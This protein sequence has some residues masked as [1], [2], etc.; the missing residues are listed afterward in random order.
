MDKQLFE[1][2]SD[3][4]LELL[5]RNEIGNIRILSIEYD[6]RC[7]I[8]EYAKIF[9]NYKGVAIDEPIIEIID[10]N[11]FEF[12]TAG[13]LSFEFIGNG[14]EMGF[15]IFT[16][17]VLRAQLCIDRQGFLIRGALT[18][19]YVSDKCDDMNYL[20]DKTNAKDKPWE[21]YTT[22]GQLLDSYPSLASV[23]TRL[24]LEMMGVSEQEKEE[25]EEGEEDEE[26]ENVY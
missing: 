2:V 3:L 10:N 14:N 11:S 26:E 22:H 24:E 18:Q 5:I 7:H 23:N 8:T 15:V 19:V 12:D 20:L 9:F 6:S 16:A 21:L 25:E 13:S 1:T 4:D 17:I